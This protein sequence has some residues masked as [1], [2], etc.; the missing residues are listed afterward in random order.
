[1]PQVETTEAD[2]QKDLSHIISLRSAELDIE[3]Q[4]TILVI[5]DALKK[6]KLEK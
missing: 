2:Q 6:S 3:S 5:I 1:M 4:K